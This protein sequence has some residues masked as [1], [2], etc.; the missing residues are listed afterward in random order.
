[1]QPFFPFIH[2]VEQKEQE[3]FDQLT[4]DIEIPIEPSKQKQEEEKS[5]III[6]DIL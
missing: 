3:I 1:M 2:Q 4:L 6:I 5:S